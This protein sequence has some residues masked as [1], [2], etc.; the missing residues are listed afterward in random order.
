MKLSTCQ[1]KY[2]PREGNHREICGTVEG[3][4]EEKKT[5]SSLGHQ[6]FQ[7]DTNENHTCLNHCT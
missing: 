5:V 1:K 6:L 3:G 2:I 4:R 7:K